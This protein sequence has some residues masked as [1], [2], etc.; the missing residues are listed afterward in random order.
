MRSEEARNDGG[1]SAG[2]AVW[3]ADRDGAESAAAD[4]LLDAEE[5]VAAEPVP[6]VGLSG[7]RL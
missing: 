5:L 6:V 4:G 2:A 1:T 3:R 7:L